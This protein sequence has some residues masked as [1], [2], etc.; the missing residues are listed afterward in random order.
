M[1]D[2]PEIICIPPDIALHV[3][4]EGMKRK[5]AELLVKQ[6]ASRKGVARSTGISRCTYAV[7][8]Q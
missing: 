2:T 5:M 4:T 7:D 8:V 3:E 1:D 6:N